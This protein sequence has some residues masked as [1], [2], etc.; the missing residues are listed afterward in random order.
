MTSSGDGKP[1]SEQFPIAVLCNF[2]NT[3]KGDRDTLPAFLT[4]CQNALDLAAEN[5]KGL[6]LKFI[7]SKLEGKAQIA[8]S[9]KIF[10]KFDDLKS[11]LKQN[12]GEVKHYNHLLLDLQSCKQQPNETVAQYSL[13]L[14]SSL[15]QLQSEIH[16]SDSYKKDLPGRIA[17]TEDLALY[18]F[19]LGL[20]PNISNIIRCKS[21]KYLNSAINM[22]IEEE[23]IQNLSHRSTK[24]KVCGVCHKEG[25]SDAECFNRVRRERPPLPIQSHQRQFSNIPFSPTGQHS[26][27]SSIVC[28]YC[29]N[30]G[31]DIS[32]CR[33]RQYNNARFS[34]STNRTDNRR[35]HEQKY[36]EYAHVT[37]PPPE[38][39][40]NNDVP[41]IT[42]PPFTM[43][44]SDNDNFN[45]NH[46]N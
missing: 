19:T 23:K 1:P 11:V 24:N 13:R 7:I 46:L 16:N 9:N 35:F 21:P 29:K 40:N 43:P 38:G 20:K 28:R 25:H 5:Q 31:H 17:M 10:D 26:R 32:Q 33:K 34:N 3:Y 36:L 30:V 22:A 4:N 12:F 45:H 2:I 15:T 8:C 39:G 6:L 18:T 27:N 42:Y 14:E 44:P 41:A 37:S